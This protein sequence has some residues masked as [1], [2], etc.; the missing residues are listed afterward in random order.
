MAAHENY[1]SVGREL[2][3]DKGEK[4]TIEFAR[5]NESR[6]PRAGSQRNA[7]RRIT[8]M[9]V[10]I[11]KLPAMRVYLDRMIEILNYQF[12]LDMFLP[13]AFTNG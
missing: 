5:Q 11:G 3:V 2:E 1:V 7:G 9:S 10:G 13:I 4:A 12:Y 8:R 6:E